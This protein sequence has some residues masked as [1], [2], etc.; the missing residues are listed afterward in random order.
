MANDDE[1]KYKKGRFLPTPPHQPILQI[2]S[3][4]TTT[5]S[6]NF[7]IISNQNHPQLSSPFQTFKMQFTTSNIIALLPFMASLA[8]AAPL[9]R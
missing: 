4:N 5:P 7:I 9:T 8:A 3:N 2:T 6:N 1:L